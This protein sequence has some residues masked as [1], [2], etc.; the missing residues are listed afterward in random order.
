V[1][2]FAEDDALD[3]NN[4]LIPMRYLAKLSGE[5]LEKPPPVSVME[6][7][8]PMTD[9]RTKCEFAATAHMVALARFAD[10][11]VALHTN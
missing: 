8:S 11:Q 6:E 5:F 9:E 3:R 10:L 7:R 2:P 4:L 1:P